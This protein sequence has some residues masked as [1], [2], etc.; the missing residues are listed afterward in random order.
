MVAKVSILTM[1]L[2]LCG[3]FDGEKNISPTFEDTFQRY[4]YMC[5]YCKEGD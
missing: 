5:S 3:L 1:E 2:L 4:I